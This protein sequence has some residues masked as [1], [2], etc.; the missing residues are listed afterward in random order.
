[1]CPVCEVMS[2]AGTRLSVPILFPCAETM[3][4]DVFPDVWME[5]VSTNIDQGDPS[6]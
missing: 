5:G 4:A 3:N 2:P 1:M 6:L